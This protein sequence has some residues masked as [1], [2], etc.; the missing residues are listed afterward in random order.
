MENPKPK[1]KPAV[2]RQKQVGF[3]PPPNPIDNF[4]K[5]S[6]DKQEFFKNNITVNLNKVTSADLE[7]LKN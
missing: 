7:A 6:L 3:K 5:T 4:E 1:P 2:P